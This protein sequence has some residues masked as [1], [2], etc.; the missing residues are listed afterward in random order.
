MLQ[1]LVSLP[2]LLNW[3]GRYVKLNGS[4][5]YP[6]LRPHFNQFNLLLG[7]LQSLSSCAHYF[8]WFTGYLKHVVLLMSQVYVSKKLPYFL[9]CTSVVLCIL[10][11]AHLTNACSKLIIKKIRL[12]CMRSNLEVNTAW[13]RFFVFIVDSDHRQHISIV[14]LLLTL[15]KYSPV[16]CEIRVKMLLKPYFKVSFIQQFIIA[17]NW[18]K[19]RPH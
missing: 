17:P 19:F 5:G 10:S 15:N 11:C 7:K 18:N 12:I 6:A 2:Y 16:G 3:H 14:F 8:Q 9:T 1:P 13:F 4:L